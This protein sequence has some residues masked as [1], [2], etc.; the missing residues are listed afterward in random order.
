MHDFVRSATRL[1]K[2]HLYAFAPATYGGGAPFAWKSADNTDAVNWTGKN[3]MIH[4]YDRTAGPELAILINMEDRWVNFQL[5]P[6]RKWRRLIDTQQYF[7]T[8]EYFT[9]VNAPLPL[10]TSANASLDAP[11]P[12]TTAAYNVSTR[13]LVVLEAAP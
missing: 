3:V 9:S 1:R 5:P 13:S 7:D 6:G 4:Y 12:V 8:P 11:V 2:D 10:R